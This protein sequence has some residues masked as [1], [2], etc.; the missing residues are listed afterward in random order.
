MCQ[1][2]QGA[3]IYGMFGLKFWKLKCLNSNV[4]ISKVENWN[5][6]VKCL[7]FKNL[8]TKMSKSGCVNIWSWKLKFQ[9]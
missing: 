2:Y 6:Y 4:W 3:T 8:K 9:N 1:T 5:L 7:E